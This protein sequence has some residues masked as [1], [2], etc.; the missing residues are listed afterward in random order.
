MEQQR[1]EEETG[2]P[3]K[4][5]LPKRPER[6]L[7]RHDPAGVLSL[8]LQQRG[9]RECDR[10]HKRHRVEHE[11]ARIVRQSP[12][13]ERADQEKRERDDCRCSK[14][15]RERRRLERRLEADVHIER[16]AV[17]DD[18]VADHVAALR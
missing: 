6:L 10:C 9:A 15:E 3:E 4:D 17:A 11:R 2:G 1:R 13:D 12:E 16:P 5:H 14:C 8:D 18:G 7:F